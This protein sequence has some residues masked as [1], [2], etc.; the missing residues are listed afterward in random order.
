MENNWLNLMHL[1][2]GDYDGEEDY[3]TL[4]KQKEIFYTKINS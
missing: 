3:K 4:I 2:K 1:L